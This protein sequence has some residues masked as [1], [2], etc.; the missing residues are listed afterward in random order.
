MFNTNSLL[1][2]ITSYKRLFVIET[3]ERWVIVVE[4]YLHSVWISNHCWYVCDIYFGENQ[5]ASWLHMFNT[6]E[7]LFFIP[8]IEVCFF[9]IH[10][11][12]GINLILYICFNI[13]HEYFIFLSTEHDVLV[14]NDLH[15]RRKSANIDS[16]D[17]FELSVA[18]NN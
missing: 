4:R 14:L 15:L 18:V 11:K 5:T 6:R 12:V 1:L 8:W 2:F 13:K 7:L 10:F 3:N 9:N 16:E 17:L